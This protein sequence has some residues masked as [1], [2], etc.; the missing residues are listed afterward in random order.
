MRVFAMVHL[1][2]PRH[3]AGAEMMLVSMLRPLVERGHQVDVQLSRA[4]PDRQ[5]YQLHGIT[6]H[7]F[8]DK[9][10]PIP[11]VRDADVVLTHLENTPRAS[12]LSLMAGKP[13]VQLMHNTHHASKLF[14][15]PGNL[16]VFN[17]QWMAAD[18][19]HPG[20]SV[21][22]RPPVFPEDYRT[23]PGDR[24]TL[25]NLN[26][27]KGG[28]LF[29]KLAES[30]PDVQF[31]AVH[32]A[33]GEQI[34]RHDLPNVLVVPHG[35]DMRA[36]YSRTKV[37]LMPSS[38]ESWGRVGVEAMCSGIPVIAHPTPGLLESLGP[39][40][41]FCDRDDP[42]AW[43]TQ[44]NRLLTPRQWRGASVAARSRADEL[45][46]AP[47]IERWCAHLEQFARTRVAAA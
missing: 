19:D 43:V 5:P 23:I 39:A 40:G 29:W 10:D 30:M 21:I 11:F 16:A 28:E 44:I 6:V 27:D 15:R 38:Y 36:A 20:P 14:L 37:L 41:I 2:P 33:Y 17:S 18:F 31:Q 34:V 8:K 42:Q 45:D 22:V 13:L 24:V 3:C 4:T 1:M 35:Q 46:P 7:P 47:D 32:G 12:V 25:V 26:A 9:N